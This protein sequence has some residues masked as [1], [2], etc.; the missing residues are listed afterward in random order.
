MSVASNIIDIVQQRL[1]LRDY[2]NIKVVKVKIGEF[3]GVS[4][5]SLRFC[6]D[7]VKFYESMTDAE[8]IIERTPL[9]MECL[10]ARVKNFQYSGEH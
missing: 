5:D 1:N 8:L 3:A 6:F 4:P 9:S 2:P 10:H 7:I